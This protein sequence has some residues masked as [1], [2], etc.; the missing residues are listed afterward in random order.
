MGRGQTRMNAENK[1]YL[2]CNLFVISSVARNLSFR[3]RMR[4][5][6]AK[7]APRND[8]SNVAHWVELSAS[9]RAQ[10]DPRPI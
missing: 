6:V 4:F 3:T 2:M 10:S 7:T 5:L 8:N 9:I 1:N